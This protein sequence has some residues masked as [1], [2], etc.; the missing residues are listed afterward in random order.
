MYTFHGSENVGKD[1]Q[2]LLLGETPKSVLTEKIK[3]RFSRT[4]TK[5]DTV[6]AGAQLL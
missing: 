3:R 5:Y 6:F 2:L 1:F 4:E